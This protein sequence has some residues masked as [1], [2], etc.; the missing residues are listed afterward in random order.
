MGCIPKNDGGAAVMVWPALDANQW[1][2]G[3]PLELCD[4]LSRIY[5][6]SDAREVV[7][8][9]RRYSPGSGLEPFEDQAR[10]EQGARERAI[11][12]LLMDSS[13]TGLVRRCESMSRS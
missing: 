1:Q 13:V 5:K 3:V 8:K 7:V 12:S 2:M 10:C 11:L 9:E 4:K 6:R